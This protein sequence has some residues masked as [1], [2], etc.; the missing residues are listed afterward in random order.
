MNI[1]AVF[2]SQYPGGSEMA[3]L[4]TLEGLHE[5]G[6]KIHAI[7]PAEGPLLE[8]LRPFAASV[9]VFP[10]NWFTALPPLI[11]G[12]RKWWFAKGYFLQALAMRKALINANA[13]R[14]ITNSISTPAAA[15]ACK[16]LG[17]PHFWYL[18]EF[19]PED[20]NL[21]Y[22]YGQRF[23]AGNMGKLSRY[24]IVN[25]NA[26][27]VSYSRFIP[28]EKL[29]LVPYSVSMPKQERKVMPLQL[30]TL[31]VV[32]AGRTA[33]GKRQEDAVRALKILLDKNLPATLTLIG[34][35]DEKYGK[36]IDDLILKLGITPFVNIIGYTPF[37]H[38][39]VREA[40]V[41]VVCSKNEAFGRVT[42]EAMKL[43][44]PVAA[45]R[46]AGT[47]E[48]IDDGK[49]GLLFS[50]ENYRE[51]AERLEQLYTETGLAER[52][53]KNAYSFAWDNFNTQ[54]HSEGIESLLK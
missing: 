47:I 18:H 54:K 35:R 49:T 11:S 30:K 20:H 12:W 44:I 52:I 50:P 53:S 32:M 9:Q 3:L 26:V 37:P 8:R 31:H 1:V 23:T 25:S 15:M 46:S 6:H 34:N 43:G 33:A 7:A 4:E 36:L 21:Q 16:L 19:G 28:R 14:V 51:L 10:Y 42:V 41:A 29:K 24:V 38:N 48:L 22:I 45:T 2:N 27:L 39:L 40:D 17:I 5:N 13:E